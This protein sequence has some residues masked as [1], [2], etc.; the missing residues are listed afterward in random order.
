MGRKALVSF[1]AGRVQLPSIMLLLCQL[2]RGLEAFMRLLRIAELAIGNTHIVPGLDLH[3]PAGC[4]DDCLAIVV[5]GAIEIAMLL[6]I[7][8]DVEGADGIDRMDRH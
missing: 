3:R 5:D 6:L 2:T 8:A 4:E 7:K 1:D